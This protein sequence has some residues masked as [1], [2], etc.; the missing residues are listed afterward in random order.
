MVIL[1]S[2]LEYL[3]HYLSILVED[4]KKI[5]KMGRIEKQKRLIIEQANRR[6]LNEQNKELSQEYIDRKT[7]D[8]Q[9]LIPYEV[10]SGDNIDSI[11]K[12]SKEKEDGLHFLPFDKKL[13]D[14]IVN[15]DEIFP[16]DVLF[17]MSDPTKSMD[18]MES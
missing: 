8:I 12:K 17:F 18:K 4:I 13:N 11:I 6:L 7:K 10:K 5:K 2:V 1:L 14:H 15:P 16:G 9:G 3:K